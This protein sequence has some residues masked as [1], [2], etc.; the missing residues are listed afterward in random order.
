MTFS[1]TGWQSS[2]SASLPRENGEQ[3]HARLAGC[4]FSRP[5]HGPF[6]RVPKATLRPKRISL[7]VPDRRCGA[8]EVARTP[9]RARL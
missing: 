4:L 8:G 3:A 1:S 2:A 6:V 9:S 5:H 7:I